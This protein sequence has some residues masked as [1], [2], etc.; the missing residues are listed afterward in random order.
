MFRIKDERI[1]AVLTG[2]LALHA[3][4][5]A[6]DEELYVS[7]SRLA[8]LLIAPCRCQHLKRATL[9][10][11]WQGCLLVSANLTRPLPV[12]LLPTDYYNSEVSARI[13][14]I[15]RAASL[16]Q[17]LTAARLQLQQ[18]AQSPQQPSHHSNA[19]QA[20]QHAEPSKA[21]HDASQDGNLDT[22]ET[23]WKGTEDTVEHVSQIDEPLEATMNAPEE[24]LE[25]LTQEDQEV[26]GK[27]D[28]ISSRALGE[29]LK[30][31]MSRKK[32]ARLQ[33]RRRRIRANRLKAHGL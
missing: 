22:A 11:R 25:D 32:Q 28:G 29:G 5:R 9:V 13:K 16:L 30:G 33:M 26:V 7:F 4:V 15:E 17:S 2:M 6:P 27:V 19:K 12:A 21:S 24:E 14:T 10:H 8:L 3:C 18:M 20:E 1:A 31:S 23:V